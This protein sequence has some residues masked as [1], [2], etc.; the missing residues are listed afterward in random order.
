MYQ[1]SSALIGQQD[2]L[3]TSAIQRLDWRHPER[4]FD[5]FGCFLA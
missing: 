3:M 5:Y 1:Q 4:K 2:T